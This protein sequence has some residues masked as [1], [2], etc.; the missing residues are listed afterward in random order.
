MKI[1]FFGTPDFASSILKYLIE[2]S[3][4]VVG[5]VTQPDKPKGRSLQLSGSAVKEWVLSSCSSIPLFQ[6][7]TC[8]DPLFLDTLKKLNA[9]LYVVVAFGQILPQALLDIPPLGCVNVHAS[10]LP[11]Y[12]G[13]APMQRC[14]MNGDQETGVA[15]QK[16]VFQ[17]DAGDVLASAKLQISQNM[18]LTELE[19]E[20]C[21]LA[22]PLLLW[23][24]Q[25][26]KEGVPKGHPQNSSLVTYAPKIHPSE[27][28]IDWNLPATRIH[29]LIRG[30]SPRP[31]A[32]CWMQI[33]GD[34]KRVKILRSK[35]VSDQVN[36]KT[37]LLDRPIVGCKENSLEL[38]EV[39]PEGKA[40]MSAASWFRG[41]RFSPTLV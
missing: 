9:D 33:Q 5:V 39:Q 25:S 20:L 7:N 15:I 22:K 18:I 28:E 10:L 13:A 23:T 26:F 14:L 31:G 30:I 1:L 16:M 27:T 29:D 38:L 32:W 21:E 35:V 36:W 17:L 6:P 4:S 8:K 41:L 37:F 40:A 11:K 34:K 24:L 3:V 19:K 12:R 2:A